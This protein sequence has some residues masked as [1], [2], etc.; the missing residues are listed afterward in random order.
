LTCSTCQGKKQMG[1]FGDWL[2]LARVFW[3]K[4]FKYSKGWVPN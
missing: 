4:T 1:P 3:N 2:N